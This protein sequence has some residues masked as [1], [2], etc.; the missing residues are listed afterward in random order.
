MIVDTLTEFC[1]GTALNTGLAGTYN[2]GN[3]IDTT[4]VRDIGM[5]TDMYLVVSMKTSAT[6][7]G[8]ATGQFRVVSDATSTISTTTA[9]VH[10]TSPAFTVANMTAGTTLF[11]IELPREGNAY[12]QF[13]GVQQ[14][15]GTAAFTGGAVDAFLTLDPPSWKAY[16]DAVN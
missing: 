12:Q 16:A 15:T 4:N 5:E 11:A 10:V 14:L 6:S 1:A 7:G 13:I 9:T 8:A 2:I 3:I